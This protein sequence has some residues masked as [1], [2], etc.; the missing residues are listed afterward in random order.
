VTSLL[1]VWFLAMAA[2]I[3]V[4]R[5]RFTFV[6]DCAAGKRFPPPLSVKRSFTSMSHRY[7]P[8]RAS[9]WGFNRVMLG[10]FVMLI[11]V[12]G[13]GTAAQENTPDAAPP[14]QVGGSVTPT[15]VS[16][17]ALPESTETIIPP[18]SEP[19]AEETQPA[20]TVTAEATET[21]TPEVTETP[22]AALT[23][24]V[25]AETAPETTPT[26]AD[27]LVIPL[28]TQTYCQMNIDDAGDSDPFSFTFSATSAN[29]ASWSW[30]FGDTNTDSGETVN[31]TY[32][33]PNSYTITLT[34]TP[35]TGFGS[36]LVLTGSV[37]ISIPSPVAYFT[38]NQGTTF[39]QIV[40]VSQPLT[41]TTNNLSTPNGLTY[42]WTVT[43]PAADCGGVM[44]IT[45][46][47]VSC[48][49][50][51]YGSY[52]F[53]LTATNT[54]GSS[55][56]SQTVVVNAPAPLADFTVTPSSGTAPLGVTFMGVM[57]ADSGPITTWEWDFDN[58]NTVDA[59]GQNPGVYT[60]TTPGLYS[61]KL[62]VTGPGGTMQIIRSVNVFQSGNSVQAAFTM[63]Q[64]GAGATP[65]TVQVCFANNSTG[66]IQTYAWDFGDNGSTDSTTS[67]PYFCQDFP[68]GLLSVRLRVTGPTPDVTSQAFRQLNLVAAPV[69]A[70]TYS[71]NSGLTQATQIDFNSSSST[72]I[73]TSYAWDF[74]G[75]GTVDSTDANPQD[76]Q[77]AIGSNHARLTVTGPGGS[78]S[79]EQI[80]DVT[81]LE[82]TCTI[83]GNFAPLPGQLT[84]TYTSS[85]GNAAGRAITYS[86]SITGG[87]TPT[88]ASNESSF[89]VSL[90]G[91]G[92]YQVTLTASTLDGSLC[93]DTRTITVTY[94]PLVCSII[95]PLPSPLYP[96]GQTYTFNAS[97]SGTAGRSISSYQWYVDGGLQSDADT[98]FDWT[99]PAPSTGNHT[100][101]YLA[102]ASD[103][104]SCFEEVA[105][106][107]TAYPGLTCTGITGP[108]S[109]IP[110]NGSG[111]SQNIQYTAGLTGLVGNR[112]AEYTWTVQGAT[113][114]TA[115]NPTNVQWP[116]SYASN[117][118]GRASSIAVNIVVHTPGEE[119]TPLTCSTSANV[120]IEN[121]VCNAPVGDLTPVVGETNSYNY[122][123]NNLYGRT[124]VLSWE[125]R[126]GINVV[127]AGSG[128]SFSYQ[129]LQ[130]GESYTLYYLASVSTPQADSCN[131]SATLTVTGTSESF[132]CDAFPS[133]GNN[134]SPASAG[135][136]A[137]TVDIDNGNLIPL[138]YDYVLVGP[139]GGERIIGSFE[140][141]ADGLVTGPSPAFTLNDLGPIGSYTLRVDVRAV[142]PATTTYT[143][144]LGHA[145]VVGSLN[146]A[147]TY[148]DGSGGAVNNSAVEVGTPICFTNTSTPVP[149][150]PSN[151]NAL[152]YTWEINGTVTNDLPGCITFD[153]AETSY[154]VNLTGVND[155][156]DDASYRREQAYNVVFNVYGS[157]SITI[158]RSNPI[159]APA[160][161]DFTAN[162][163]NIDSYSWTFYNQANSVVGTGTGQNT[164]L[165]VVTPGTYR[166]VVTGMGDLG[167]TTA[168]VMFTLIDTDDILASFIPS[169]YA[170]VAPMTVCFDDTSEGQNLTDWEWNFGNGETLIYD[171]T[172]I[173]S[174]I[175]TTYPTAD[176]NYP[177]TLVVRNQ[178]GTEATATN[179]IRTYSVLESSVTYHITP[180]G[181][182]RY[183]FTAD[184]SPGVTVTGW[185]FGDGDTGGPANT[186]C[187][188]FQS[189]GDFRVQMSFEGPGGEPGTV[190]RVVSVS[191]TGGTPT[192]AASAV[193]APNRTAT[194]T[195]TNSGD[196]MTTADQIV[197][198]NA[199]G[200]VIDVRPVQLASGAQLQFSLTN[201]SGALTLTLT[202]NS[203]VTAT[204]TCYYPPE[205]T[206]SATCDNG[207]PVFTVTNARPGD[208]PMI[209]P[210]AYEIQDADGDVV[211]SGTFELGLGESSEVITLPSN[212]PTYASYTFV[213]SGAVG[214]FSVSH[215][216][217]APQVTVSAACSAGLPVFTV[218]NPTP[219]NPMVVPQTYEIQDAHGAVVASGTFQLSVGQSAQDI[220]LP[221]NLPAYAAY[222]FVSSGA[223]GTLEMTHRCAAPVAAPA[224]PALATASVCA[225]G[226][227]RFIVT[228]TTASAIEAQ[229]YTIVGQNGTAAEG[230]LSIAP[231][232]AQTILLPASGSG[233]G[234]YSLVL[235][236]TDLPVI[237][238]A[239]CGEPVLV[240]S[241]VCGAP[242]AFT[243][244]N[245]GGAMTAGQTYTLSSGA[246]DLTP[247]DNSF[248]LAAGETTRITV[249]AGANLTAGVTFRTAGAVA[250]TSRL[251]C[252]SAVSAVPTAA[253]TEFRFTGLPLVENAPVC[254]Y[255]CPT[256]QLYAT[257]ETGDWEIFRLES[258]DELTRTTIRENLSLGVGAGVIDMAPS[259]SPDS[260]WIVFQSNR[261]G[262]WE[263]YVAPTSGGDPDAVQRL[264]YNSIA[265][266]G[267]PVW[268]PNNFVV[269]E[270]TRNGNY[271]LYLIDMSTG[272]EYQLTDSEGD[273]INPYWSPDGTR[274]VFQ[275]D[276]GSAG[277]WQLFEL[278]IVTGQLT[279][280]SDN[281]AIEV[282]PQYS[283]D[284]SQIVFRTYASEGDPS[285]LMIM[286]ADGNNR[287]AISDPAGDA[288]NAA[289]SPSDRY[290]AY[291]S[292]LDGDLDVYIYDVAAGETRQLTDNASED[293]APTWRCSDE[294][295]VFTSDITEEPNIYEA[296][297]GPLDAPAIA[298][299]EDA[300][301]RTFEPSNDIYPQSNPSEEN[302][303]RE[304]QTLLGTFGEQ[305]VFLQ[306]PANITPVDESFDGLQRDEWDEVT[307]CPTDAS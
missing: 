33:A 152:A 9:A 89:G 249:P 94:P 263:L 28:F 205:I 2:P 66:P 172:T 87:A 229:P 167:P 178:G 140:S 62:T 135:S 108:A 93:S 124:P 41:I 208:G 133:A 206:V 246:V 276:R 126:Q 248:Q 244:S 105:A 58:N 120:R 280:L 236:D 84:Q 157:Q 44:P 176:S 220:T 65:G 3:T 168:E 237:V 86:W 114:A 247:A 25:T 227:V 8:Y 275:S 70:F 24:E 150:V 164:S 15:I 254:A 129:F 201:Q 19:T 186:V 214:T 269:Y 223:V 46:T 102:T 195:I 131:A 113:S 155:Y 101:R 304:G 47:N 43:G 132:A 107:I 37:Q 242:A 256:F 181:G 169:Q 185:D 307:A 165:N 297:A 134:F 111:V 270:S 118:T 266:D 55:T 50:T 191:L 271:D 139:N 119:D 53:E 174:E 203:S 67:A 153:T 38:L 83:E 138:H 218:T 97:V 261:D 235:G 160:I 163:V 295:V 234:S 179:I 52:I 69:A 202:D 306:P 90:P 268:G 154:T 148:V 217:G 76:M 117:G 92:T 103:G 277:R 16:T 189:T 190:E 224:S 294:R 267:D 104:S 63:T 74:D 239:T 22:E 226:E 88:G 188:Q 300:D 121:L 77:L 230:V 290:L 298:V 144:S 99:N 182:G 258:A 147:F 116:L 162:G 27:S 75:N 233:S 159:Y 10:L 194:F 23:P 260:H 196:A 110:V 136:Y 183:C 287:R 184:I 30:D 11:L 251:R 225:N 187:H 85:I 288:T 80:I 303:S 296:D 215:S 291:Q 54:S 56:F 170:G 278:N 210:Q 207:L 51:D 273:D 40:N 127:A 265:I 7:R 257:D 79:A 231:G 158:T 272:Q 149:P 146:V 286:D 78:S 284:G 175:C 106:N 91:A 48:A 166:A 193:C 253:P 18:T 221:S 200:D 122:S 71:P 209:S 35:E 32:A 192:L 45:T 250:V 72:G 5:F 26:S 6:V 252:G 156:Q 142:N 82:I 199:N 222:T 285:T 264:T 49:I 128:S 259:L 238:E 64:T 289:W 282:D 36:P 232:A 42:A 14:D 228:N 96:N 171:N 204:T 73:I 29:I 219:N 213:S 245:R 241:S 123:I 262:N 57:D 60:Y 34:C 161:V 17:P 81:R 301:Q 130:P 299:D 292:D 95:N 12:I 283:H 125:L 4:A 240:M 1:A 143:C 198:R 197:V 13:S 59:T 21:G 293:Y 61:A 112:T 145:L 302:A 211:S 255:G 151:Q 39:E 31:H 212:L 115:T 243:V 68:S 216:C 177:V 141:S 109:P 100:I 173:P 279:G 274:V 305:T 98:S 137:Y 180:Q 281:S 20:E